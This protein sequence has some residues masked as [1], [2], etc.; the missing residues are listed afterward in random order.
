V[1]RKRVRRAL[2]G[3]HRWR[4]VLTA[5]AILMV[6]VTAAPPA[7]AYVGPGAGITV[8]GTVL[9]V[10]AAIFL[11]IVGFIWYPV[12]R[13]L[14]SRKGNAAKPERPARGESGQSSP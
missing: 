3:L 2:P 6:T 11:G 14:R 5:I 9:A 10:I 1:S 7:D 4:T 8:I 13:L 12:R